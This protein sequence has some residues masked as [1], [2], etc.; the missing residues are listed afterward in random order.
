MQATREPGSE[1][2]PKGALYPT[3]FLF[4]IQQRV[5]MDIREVMPRTSHPAGKR[6]LG[7]DRSSDSVEHFEAWMFA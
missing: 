3:R 2:I 4:N 1:N 7:H 5:D 6:G